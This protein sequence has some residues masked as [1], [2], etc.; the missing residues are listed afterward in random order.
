MGLIKQDTVYVA[1]LPFSVTEADLQKEFKQVGGILGV[2]VPTDP[3][4]K[5]GK[6]FAF[7]Q[8][9]S[10]RSAK[11]LLNYDGHLYLGRKMRISLAEKKQ[12]ERKRS[13]SSER[14][15]RKRRSRHS[16]ESE[17]PR[18]RQRERRQRERRQDSHSSDGSSQ[19]SALSA[20]EAPVLRA[21][22]KQRN[23]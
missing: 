19:S 9:D 4:T 14:P 1:N 6:G 10:E 23:E 2:R 7:I 20:E 3:K 18:S 5:Q 21:P 11:K 22:P 16:S 13:S 8:L 17:R 15:K 12:E